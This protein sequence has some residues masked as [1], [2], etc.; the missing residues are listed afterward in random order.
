MGGELAERFV[1]E[2]AELT[3]VTPIEAILFGSRAR[4][5]ATEE[6]DYDLLLIYDEVTPAVQQAIDALW[7]EY[8]LEHC[9]VMSVHLVCHE[10]M[11]VMRHEPFVINARREGVC[12]GKDRGPRALIPV[13][14]NRSRARGSCDAESRG[15]I[16]P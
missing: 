5:D 15:G 13:M 3:G 14:T 10:E 6:S 7:T 4:G 2:L 12:V 11:R 1:N 16:E 9:A 8:L